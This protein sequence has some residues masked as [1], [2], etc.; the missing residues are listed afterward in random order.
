MSSQ[1]PERYK[2]LE[3]VG[4]GSYGMVCSAVDSVRNNAPVAIKKI[5]PMA[6]HR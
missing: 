2:I 4:K 3:A 6:A 1:I 5:T